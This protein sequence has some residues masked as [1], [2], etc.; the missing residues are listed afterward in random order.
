MYMPLDKDDWTGMPDLH[1]Q[2][3]E[4]VVGKE[5]IAAGS[6]HHE[7]AQG[8]VAVW[9]LGLQQGRRPVQHLIHVTAHPIQWQ[10]VCNL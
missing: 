7:A 6:C 1:V 4:R 2:A 3:E 8:R 5:A 10:I 9:I